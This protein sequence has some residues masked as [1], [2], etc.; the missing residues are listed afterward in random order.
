MHLSVGPAKD[1]SDSQKDKSKWCDFHSDHGHK[2]E[3][4]YGLKRE[5]A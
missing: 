3:D 1:K 5:I 2:A 4:C